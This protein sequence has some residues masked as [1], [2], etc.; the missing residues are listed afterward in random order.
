K[1]MEQ[2]RLL[3]ITGEE[4]LLAEEII[5][6][7]DEDG[8]LRRELHLIVQDL[9]LT[10]GLA[11]TDAQAEAVLK[12]IQRLD[13]AGIGARCL[14]ECL[15]SQ[16]EIGDYPQPAREQALKILGEHFQD[17]SMKHYEDL[18]RKLGSSVED[19]RPAVE[20]IQ[21]LNPKPGEGQFTAQQNY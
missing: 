9:N 16:L 3:D 11:I 5:G 10:H 2:I 18:A 17:F 8:Y 21:K 15:V 13:P 4:R 6:N 1:L 14:Q 19:L 7:I 12:K 20:L